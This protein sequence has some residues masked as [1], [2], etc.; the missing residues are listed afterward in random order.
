MLDGEDMRKRVSPLFEENFTGLGELG[1]AVSIWQKGELVIDL[2]GGFC[3]ARRE[4]PWKPDSLVLVWSATKGVGSA[5]LLHALQE[6]GIDLGRRVAEFWP[7]FA[8]SGKGEITIAQ[9]VSHSA[10]LCALGE[11]ADVT[12]YSA[13]IRA[14]ERQRPVWFPATAHGYHARTFGFLIDELTRRITGISISKYWRDVFAE[15]L[16]L[17]FWIGLPAELN[18]RCA[19]VY[20]AKSGKPPEP[21]PFYRDLVTPGTLQHRTFA[22]PYGLHAI[23]AMNKPENHALDIVSF[24]GIGSA[25]ALGKFYAMLANGGEMN[26]QRFYSEK[27]LALM[28]TG[29]AD[30]MDRVFEI[31]TAFSAGFMKDASRSRRKIFA[32]FAKA[33]G[34]PGAGG[35]HAFADPETGIAFA[36]VMNQMEQTLL[37]NEKSLRLVDAIYQSIRTR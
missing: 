35:S 18:T 2:H 37:P 11:N 32:P 33:F 7:E 36:Y 23:S 17:D 5:C 14:L 13:V 8:Q 20:A 16:A 21:V 12:D 15:P 1:A 31:P 28:T 30:G 3:D 6:N 22:S 29:I 27:T 9:L 19:T 26:G 25:Y 4:Q 24:G 10:G 34:Y